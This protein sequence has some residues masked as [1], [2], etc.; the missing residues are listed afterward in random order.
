MYVGEED[1]LND[2]TSSSLELRVGW[3]INELGLYS[4]IVRASL[5]AETSLE[6]ARFSL[7]NR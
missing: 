7:E 1:K 6:G 3:L 2:K 4:F 5:A